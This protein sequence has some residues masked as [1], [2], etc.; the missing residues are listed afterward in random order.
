MVY[1]GEEE[2]GYM[3]TF[4]EALEVTTP[5]I[6]LQIYGELSAED[7]EGLS[8]NV[9]HRIFK[10]TDIGTSNDQVVFEALNAAAKSY[11]DWL[12]IYDFAQGANEAR[13][14]ALEQLA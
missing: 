14:S 7:L 9:L 13:A 10:Q 4:Q 8:F 1:W 6:A 12:R 5:A 2:G 11:G 3:L